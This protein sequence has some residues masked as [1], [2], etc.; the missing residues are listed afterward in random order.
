MQWPTAGGHR[1]R[2]GSASLFAVSLS[3]SS[4]VDAQIY[5]STS[6]V[7]ERRGEEQKRSR[8]H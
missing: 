1:G 4:L 8:S 5:N 6:E 3:F 2:G 7:R